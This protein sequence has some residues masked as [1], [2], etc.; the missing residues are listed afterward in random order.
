M[1]SPGN[2][3]G[4]YMTAEGAEVERE[5]AKFIGRTADRVLAPLRPLCSISALSAVGS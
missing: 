3:H 4:N 2:N 1:I 5:N